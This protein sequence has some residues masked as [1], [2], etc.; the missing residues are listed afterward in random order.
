MLGGAKFLNTGQDAERAIITL[1]VM[2]LPI[3]IYYLN[4]KLIYIG[5]KKTTRW[6]TSR[7][8][9]KVGSY[10]FKKVSKFKYLGTMITLLNNMEYEILKGIQMGN[11]YYYSLGNLI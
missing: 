1:P 9:L 6:K 4:N 11:K 5:S 10:S 8:F 7:E 3:T 2:T